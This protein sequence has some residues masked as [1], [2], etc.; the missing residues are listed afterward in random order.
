MTSQTISEMVD[1]ALGMTVELS[2]ESSR[3]YCLASLISLRL[4]EHSIE[5]WRIGN[6]RGASSR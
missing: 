5:L 2:D 6:T 3:Q 1:R 4:E